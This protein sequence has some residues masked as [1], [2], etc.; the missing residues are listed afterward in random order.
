MKT[1]RAVSIL[2]VSVALVLAACG[3][4]PPATQAQSAKPQAPPAWVLKVPEA[5]AQYMYFTGSGQSK[6]ASMAEAEGIAR[7]ALLD[8]IMQYMGVRITAETTATAK[9]TLESY[10]ADLVQT[11]TSTSSARVA[12]LQLAERWVSEREG[13]ASVYLL[14]R[15]GKADLAKEKKRLEELFRERVEAVSGPEKEGQELEAEGRLYQAALSFLTAA[16]AAF[17]SDLENADIKFERNMNQAREAVRR[18]SLIKFN[19]N[20]KTYAGQDFAEPFSAA[21]VNGGR[22]SDPPIADAAVRVSYKE[23]KGTGKPV[24]RTRTVKSDPQGRV[25]FKPPAPELVGREELAMS[26]D[27]SDALEALEAVP[28]RLY[29]QV[30]AFQ[31]LLKTKSVSFAYESRSRAAAVAT[32]IAVFDLDATGSPI[33]M[34][35][36]AAGLLGELGKAG[37][38]VV[39][40]PVTADRVAGRQDAQVLAALADFQSQVERVIF[41]TARIADSDQEGS[42]IIIQVTGTVKVVE[43]ATGKVLLTAN[44]SKRAQGGNASAALAA[45]FKMLGEDFGQTIANQ[46][47]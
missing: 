7:G 47:R 43:L 32:G 3:S 10:Q 31:D 24:T 28:D 40:L 33:S 46:L 39:S 11:I 9:A 12:G 37:F 21:V 15:Y 25:S 38:K 19:D 1:N 27:L 14:A 42:T 29:G 44:R 18:I 26:L 13:K 36:T 41:G 8:S 5:D 23:A 6:T 35:E 22:P 30:E 45:A 16:A 4:T 34:A 20:L 2:A 17:K